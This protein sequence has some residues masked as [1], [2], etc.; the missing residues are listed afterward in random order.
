MMCLDG[1]CM[2]VGANWLGKTVSR[3]FDDNMFSEWDML[4]M[5]RDLLDPEEADVKGRLEAFARWIVGTGGD[6][7]A[8][9]DWPGFD[10]MGEINI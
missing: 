10:G 5:F 8:V 6:R 4:D 7:Q 3:S 1:L 2:W 9:L